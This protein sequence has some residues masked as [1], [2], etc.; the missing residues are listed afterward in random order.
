MDFT[1]DKLIA[2]NIV[3]EETVYIIKEYTDADDVEDI[4]RLKQDS[5]KLYVGLKKSNYENIDETKK[6]LNNDYLEC[7]KYR[8]ISLSSMEELKGKNIKG[9][10]VENC[11][12]DNVDAILSLGGTKITSSN[13]ENIMPNGFIYIGDVICHHS[14]DILIPR[15]IKQVI[16]TVTI[17]KIKEDIIKD[18]YAR[19][20]I[21]NTDVGKILAMSG[22]SAL[23]SEEE[24][25]KLF[26]K[27]T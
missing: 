23:Y 20:V 3:S 17:V 6:R 14:L 2:E 18:L 7:E 13:K 21:Q 22:M 10:Q 12:F 11:N 26:Q 15:Y 27:N 8:T 5:M 16:L 1:D 9:I 25:M 24:W 4:A 19:K